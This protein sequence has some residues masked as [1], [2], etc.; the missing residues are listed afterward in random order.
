MAL[1]SRCHRRKV[2][3]HCPALRADLCQLCCG[4]LRQKKISCPPSCRFLQH[5][6][7]QDERRR[8]KS[9]EMVAP[10]L[11]DERL[12]FLVAQVEAGLHQLAAENSHFSD[13]EAL[14]ALEYARDRI[15]AGSPRIILSG[16]RVDARATAGEFILKI[17]DQARYGK[18]LLLS[19]SPSGYSREEKIACLETL[20]AL[21]LKYSGRNLD[22]RLFL[23]E[24]SRRLTQAEREQ[25]QKRIISP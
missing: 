2:K 11:D 4:D 18:T 13:R 1:C 9:K 21:I 5:Q 14:S 19:V 16:E 22:Q 15:A 10:R 6:T 12:A 17:V 24:L 8:Q 20:I 25:R 3:R 23:E 7:Y